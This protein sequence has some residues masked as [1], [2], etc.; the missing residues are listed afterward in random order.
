VG[1]DALL[2]PVVDGS[3]VDDLLEVVP[4]ALDFQEPLV[5]QGDVLG[6]ELGVGAAEQV[7][8]VE[9][10][11]DLDGGGRRSGAGRRG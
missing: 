6:G 7:L 4:A 1:A 2:F 5:P 3:Q 10:L 11:L 8:A 9:V